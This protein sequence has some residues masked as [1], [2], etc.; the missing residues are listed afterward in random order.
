MKKV[1]GLIGLVIALAIGY[2][3][4]KAEMTQGPTGGAP[5]KQVI[6]TTAV[7]NDLAAIGHAEQMYLASHGSYGSFD[8]LKQ[9]A[10][11][12]FSDGSRL[13]YQY[14][15]DFNDGQHFEITATPTDPA[16]KSWPTV[17]IDETMQISKQ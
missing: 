5:P 9:E 16:K 6:D 4:F 3:V 15:V 12:T 1:G 8:Q 14:R 7:E 11:T 13:G 17:S 2:F 10:M